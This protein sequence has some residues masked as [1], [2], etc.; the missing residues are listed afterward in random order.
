MYHKHFVNENQTDKGPVI[1][2]GRGGDRRENG[3]VTEK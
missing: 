1:I 2:Y 3:G